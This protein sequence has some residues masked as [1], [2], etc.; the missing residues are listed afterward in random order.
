MVNNSFFYIDK[1]QYFRLFLNVLDHDIKCLFNLYFESNLIY[2]PFF[3][4]DQSAF[5]LSPTTHPPT[6]ILTP[7]FLLEWQNIFIWPLTDQLSREFISNL[8]MM[9]CR[10]TQTKRKNTS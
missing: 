5:D 8:F 1:M 2:S 4:F 9:P 6:D 3:Q 7:L 10:R